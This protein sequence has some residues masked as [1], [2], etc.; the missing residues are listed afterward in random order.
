MSFQV[1]RSSDEHTCKLPALSK[2]IVLVSIKHIFLAIT[3]S[4]ALNLHGVC[5][6]SLQ[7]INAFQAQIKSHSSVCSTL[8]GGGTGL[9]LEDRSIA[10]T[11]TVVYE[12][13]IRSASGDSSGIHIWG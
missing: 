1:R 3:E 8:R 6:F 5:L 13:E 7:N 11:E 9:Y 10:L 4:S 12:K 2:G